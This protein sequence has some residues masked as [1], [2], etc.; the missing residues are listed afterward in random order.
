MSLHPVVQRTRWLNALER[1]LIFAPP[2]TRRAT[3][4]DLLRRSDDLC[5]LRI[6]YHSA[7]THGAAS[8]HAE[9]HAHRNHEAPALLFLHGARSDVALST[10]R[11][12]HLQALGFGVLAVDYRGFGHSG[13]ELPSEAS[14]CE[15]ALAAWR[16]LARHQAQRPRYIYGHSLGGA[17]AI[18][19]A[20]AVD[21]AAGLIVDSSF[22]CLTDVVRQFHWGWAPILN[23][24][25]QRFDAA[26]KIAAVQAPVLVVHGDADRLVPAD[27]GRALCEGATAPK[28][29]VLVPGGSHHN[30]H[31]LGRQAY[32]EAM[33]TFF[34]LPG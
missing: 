4:R 22:T 11:I 32:R 20:A 16:W 31:A 33:R 23:C 25:T 1:R 10:D 28:R 15:D 12:R 6:R 21:D 18:T 7:L 9:W 19:L 34:G 29:F 14:A 27:L 30:T 17:I 24:I 3:V 5:N 13:R 26:A 8:L 2:A